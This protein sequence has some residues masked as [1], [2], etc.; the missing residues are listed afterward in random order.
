MQLCFS[1]MQHLSPL[2]SIQLPSKSVI[3]HLYIDNVQKSKNVIVNAIESI[4]FSA[5]SA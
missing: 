2:S 3:C 5:G 1:E 4:R